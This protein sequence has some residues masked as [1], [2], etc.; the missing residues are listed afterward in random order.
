MHINII[1][2]I[3][4]VFHFF[5]LPLFNFSFSVAKKSYIISVFDRI[6]P[7]YDQLNHILSL[8]IDKLW[9]KKAVKRIVSKSPQHVLDVACGTG[10]FS[11]A[12]AKAGVAKVEGID[13]SEGMMEVGRKKVADLGL[14]ESITMHLDDCE[15]LSLATGS[16]DA[17]TVAFGVRNFE[18]LPVGLKE[19]CRVL[20]DGGEVCVLELSVPLNP[21]L[22]WGYK[23]YFLHILPWIGGLVSGQKDAYKY[24]P[25]SVLNFPKPDQFCQMLKEAGFRSVEA[26]SYTFGLCRMFIGVK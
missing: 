26:H 4:A 20:R 18:H 10:D 9:R 6:A 23:L 24:L 3:P 8:N 14:S 16:V 15:S 22:L 19:M 5:N 25:M 7:T 1:I 2:P 11:I 12:L 13:I 17:V 21:I